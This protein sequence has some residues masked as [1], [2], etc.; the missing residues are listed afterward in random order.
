MRLFVIKVRYITLV[1]A[2]IAISPVVSWASPGQNALDFLNLPMGA[3]SASMGKGDY[4]GIIGPEAMFLNPGQLGGQTG[5]F[6]SHQELLLD[7]RAETFAATIN[8]KH[9]L[10]IGG[11]AYFLDMGK[12]EGYSAD[13]IKTGDVDSGDRLLRLALAAHRN[14]FSIGLSISQY[15]QRL[16]EETGNGWG[17]GAG[18]SF[19][20]RLGRL[21][22]AADN[23][24]PRF[25]IGRSSAPLPE[26][27]AL[28]AWIPFHNNMVDLSLDLIVNRNEETGLAAGLEYHVTN[29]LALR[30]GG[31]R[32]DPI[33][34]GFRLAAN[35]LAFDYSYIP[36]SIFGDR[37]IFSVSF[38][39]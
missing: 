26:K 21:S 39:K 14:Q 28:S 12:V 24:G 2:L 38:L 20:H 37:H 29:G 17:L 19:E 30:A 7:I 35:R 5:A 23:I 3:Y 9:G 4:A 31:N 33:S 22:V 15:N 10:T 27:L 16:A 34:L 18:V 32:L 25:K 6:A 1:M 8:L 11:A 36:R 13:N